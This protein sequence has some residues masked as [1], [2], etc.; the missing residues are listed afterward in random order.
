MQFESERLFIRA[1][2]QGDG[3]RVNE[4][5]LESFEELNR[6]MPWAKEK[7]T[8]ADSE[9]QCRISQAK[10]IA[11]E[12]LQL[13]IFHKSSGDFIGASGLHRF[14]W[15]VPRFE[16]G[17]WCRTKRTGSGFISEAVA[18]IARFAFEELRAKRVEIYCD[19]KNTRSLSVPERLGFHL[20]GVLRNHCRDPHG[21]LRDTRV[22]SIISLA[23]L[24][25][26]KEAQR[27]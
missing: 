9:E 25:D 18:R 17:Y 4:A 2:Q 24:K 6:W 3:A 19:S 11:R 21:D 15:S 14:D 13:L 1:P 12:D 5:I 22:Y 23:D 16:I 10:F 20:D 27:S 26:N 7:P 8:P